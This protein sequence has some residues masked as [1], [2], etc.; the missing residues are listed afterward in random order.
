ML[1][2]SVAE[3][4]ARCHAIAAALPVAVQVVTSSAAVG[5]GSLP[6]QTLPSRALAFR[7]QSPDRLAAVLRAA[8][9][10]VVARIERDQVLLD[11]RTVLPDQDATLTTSLREALPAAGG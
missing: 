7:T 4:E 11:L 2:T 9:T 5:G 1:S 10:P 3:L 6:G 8:A